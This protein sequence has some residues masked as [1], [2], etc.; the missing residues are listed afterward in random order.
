MLELLA[1]E[2]RKRETG[3]ERAASLLTGILV[4]QVVR[5]VLSAEEASTSAGWL[6]GLRDPEIGAALALFTQSR[7][8]AWSVD[9]L[10]G[11]A[12]CPAASSRNALLHGWATPR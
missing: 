11:K 5:V 6:Q 4:I 2:M 1:G 12:D 10:A 9:S 8:R 3:S 7:K